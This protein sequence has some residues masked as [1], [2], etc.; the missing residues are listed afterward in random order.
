M[1]INDK[2][3]CYYNVCVISSITLFS[4]EDNKKVRSRSRARKMQS[5]FC[6]TQ[7]FNTSENMQKWRMHFYR[8]KKV[9]SNV[10][11]YMIVWQFHFTARDTYLQ[12]V[13]SL[14]SKNILIDWVLLRPLAMAANTITIQNKLN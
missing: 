4:S 7:S 6:A 2:E 11:K 1:P 9:F 8:G 3:P 14:K 10:F 13:L 12:I 5:S